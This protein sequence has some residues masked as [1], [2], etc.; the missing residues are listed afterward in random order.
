VLTGIVGVGAAEDDVEDG[1]RGEED[2]EL[3]GAGVDVGGAEVGEDEGTPPPPQL[4]KADRHP[5]PQ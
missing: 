5:V 3:G 1:G 2:D 4:P